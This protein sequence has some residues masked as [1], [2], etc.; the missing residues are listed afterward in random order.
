MLAMISPRIES[1]LL[2]L[3]IEPDVIV[4]RNLPVG[5]RLLR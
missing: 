2:K 4:E 1:I 5:E 3:G